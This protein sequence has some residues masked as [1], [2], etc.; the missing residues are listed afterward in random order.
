MNDVQLYAFW[1]YDQFPYVLGGEVV[2]LEGDSVQV[3]GFGSYWIKP[4]KLTSYEA[5]KKL[6]DEIKSI[7]I[8]RTVE[9]VNVNQKYRKQLKETTADMLPG[10]C[11]YGEVNGD[12]GSGC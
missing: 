5:G 8:S 11:C 4:I 2:K 1:S 9:L 12:H 6:H 7:A 3:K 10:L